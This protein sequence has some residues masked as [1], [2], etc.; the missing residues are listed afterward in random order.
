MAM[1]RHFAT[2]FT[3]VLALI[4]AAAPAFAQFGNPAGMMPAVPQTEPG[5]PAPGQ[6]NVQD[7]LFIHLMATGGMAEIE[8]AKMADARAGNGPVRDFARR[9][10]Q[11]HGPAHEQLAALARQAQ[12]PLPQRLDP[13]HVAARAQLESLSGPAFERAYL[14]NQLIDHQKTVQILE[15][16]IGQ[17]QEAGLQRYAAATLPVVMQHLQMVQAL[18][19]QTTGAAVREMPLVK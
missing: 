19:G 12:V 18:I 10:L 6:T 8:T 1:T 5:T 16:E 15:W 9:M 11:D 13:D 3:A 14:Q 2:F 7:R 17:G 4:L